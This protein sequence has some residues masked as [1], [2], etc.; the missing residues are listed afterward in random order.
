MMNKGLDF[1]RTYL[2]QNIIHINTTDYNSHLGAVLTS[3]VDYNINEESQY[4]IYAYTY[5]MIQGLFIFSGIDHEGNIEFKSVMVKP[6]ENTVNIPNAPKKDAKQ[7]KI[8]TDIL[9][10]LKNMYKKQ[11]SSSS[12]D[13]SKPSKVFII[14]P[15]FHSFS[16]P[17]NWY[18]IKDYINKEYKPDISF[19]IISNTSNIPPFMQRYVSTV[20]VEELYSL[21]DNIID[22]RMHQLNKYID[23]NKISFNLKD[24]IK[25]LNFTEYSNFTRLIAHAAETHI[26]TDEFV[27]Y[28]SKQMWKEIAEANGV[29][30]IIDNKTTL[31][32]LGGLYKLKHD[33]KNMA[34]IFKNQEKAQE[35]G[36]PIPKSIILQGI[37]GAGKTEMAKAIATTCDARFMVFNMGNMFGSR[38]GETEGNLSN[39]LAMFELQKPVV[40]LVD[41]VDKMFLGMESSGKSDAGTT[42]RAIQSYLTYLSTD[43]PGV[44]LVHTANDLSKISSTNP[45]FIRKG[46]HDQIYFVDFPDEE[47]RKEIFK[48]HLTK[49]KADSKLI[50]S[51]GKTNLIKLSENYT[52]AEIEEAIKEAKR[53]AFINNPSSPEIDSDTLVKCIKEIT[54]LAV[55]EADKIAELRAWGEKYAINAAALSKRKTSNNNHDVMI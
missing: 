38:L 25:T 7:L 10:Y 5:D 9:A 8:F 13:V 3:V 2:M 49:M 50:N 39:A 43:H 36:V 46:R 31:D 23:V 40:V 16:L 15:D 22:D 4:N 42:A 17:E 32:N 44:F 54:P 24:R 18:Y 51:I 52:G 48:I 29:H 11:K 27:D 26:L 37:Q 55:I 34:K 28:A 53:R 14:L 47:A 41:E 1:F 20:P 6:D 21:Y 35:L 30:L 12:K 19:I 33:I 45:E